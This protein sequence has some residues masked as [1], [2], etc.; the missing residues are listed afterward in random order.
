MLVYVCSY[1]N[2]PVYLY[3]GRSNSIIMSPREVRIAISKCPY[4]NRTFT[5]KKVE[6]VEVTPR[7]LPFKNDIEAW[8]VEPRTFDCENS[9]CSCGGDIV[10]DLEQSIVVCSKCG[11]VF[12]ERPVLPDVPKN[13]EPRYSG[14]ITHRIHDYGIGTSILEPVKAVMRGFKWAVHQSRIVVQ[15]NKRLVKLLEMINDISEIDE[16]PESVLETASFLLRKLAVSPIIEVLAPRTLKSVVAASVFVAYRMHGY[17]V[18]LKDFAKKISMSASMIWRGVSILTKELGIR[19]PLAR[20]SDY[21]C[22]ISSLLNLDSEAVSLAVKI[23]SCVPSNHGKSPKTVAI[24]AIYLAIVVLN[25]DVTRRALEEAGIKNV[26]SGVVCVLRHVRVL[27][28]I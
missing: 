12:D 8:N 2:N 4:C 22:R 27:V 13:S 18:N 14:R 5:D 11:L 9:K 3:D 20:V 25:K 10:Y 16:T 1:C 19:V 6:E 26:K 15:E 24:G 17:S 21:I 7:D 23:A 28:K